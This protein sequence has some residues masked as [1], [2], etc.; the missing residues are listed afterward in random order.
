M[1]LISID[2]QFNGTVV[3]VLDYRRAAAGRVEV[4]AIVES[5]GAWYSGSYPVVLD[6]ADVLLLLTVQSVPRPV[7]NAR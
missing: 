3:D 7:R 5:P 4:T 1:K 2:T 6:A